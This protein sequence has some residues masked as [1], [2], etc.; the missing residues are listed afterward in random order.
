MQDSDEEW[1]AEE[2][3]ASDDRGEDY[4]SPS[5][6]SLGA[7]QK[8]LE[9]QQGQGSPETPTSSRPLYVNLRSGKKA[10]KPYVPRAKRPNANKAIVPPTIPGTPPTS[11]PVASLASQAPPAPPVP[12]NPPL[13]PAPAMASRSRIRYDFFKGRKTDPESW[14]EG[15]KA[16]S[17]SNGDDDPVLR[18]KIFGGLM[19]GEAQDWHTG[20]PTPA[21]WDALKKEFLKEWREEGA[22]AKA[23]TKLNSVLM[24]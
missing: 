16:V 5:N 8:R 14:L 9:F 1:E 13:V 18:M 23:F 22:E 20:L 19:K 24:R 11:S 3:E 2:P 17:L 4:G 15:F 21:D 10:W 6:P 12:P 7:V